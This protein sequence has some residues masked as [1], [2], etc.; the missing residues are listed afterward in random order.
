METSPSGYPQWS[1]QAILHTTPALL[2][3][4]SWLVL[5]THVLHQGKSVAPR[6][7]AWYTKKDPTFSDVLAFM[8][9]TF[10]RQTPLFRMS[11]FPANN[12]KPAQR[13]P[14]Q[15]MVALCYTA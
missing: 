9:R 1:D 3:L 5:A 8:R 6:W 12:Q 10:W 11:P 2:G 4:F 7:S 15:I 13:P 14:P